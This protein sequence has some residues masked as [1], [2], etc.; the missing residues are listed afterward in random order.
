MHQTT[1]QLLAI[2]SAQF[3]Q[4]QHVLR[5][6]V[7]GTF[8]GYGYSPEQIERFLS[9]NAEPYSDAHFLLQEGDKAVA[10][11][12]LCGTLVEYIIPLQWDRR[13]ELVSA[14]LGELVKAQPSLRFTIREDLP[15]HSSWYAA[16]LPGFGFEMMPRVTMTAPTR[17]L[18]DARGR[19][20]AYNYHLVPMAP[21]WKENCLSLHREAFGHSTAQADE[22]AESLSESLETSDRLASW[23][24]AFD[25]EELVGSSFGSHHRGRLF[26]E[27]IA[28]AAEHRSRGLGRR[29]LLESVRRLSVMFPEAESVVL[30]VDRVNVPAVALYSGLGFTVS[31]F[32]TV[33]RST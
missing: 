9:L 29:L 28:V 8:P 25:G 16:L 15:S 32:Y 27:E 24:V 21:A 10:V 18:L 23:E 3:G 2:P 26:I 12:M 19:T 17:V 13:Y 6:A 20:S 1:I 30:D 33:A 5:Q 7:I 31:R 14:T 22:M 11:A 4:F